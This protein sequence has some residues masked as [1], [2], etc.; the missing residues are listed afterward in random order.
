MEQKWWNHALFRGQ[1]Y[2]LSFISY[3]SFCPTAQENIDLVYKA[4]LAPI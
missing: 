1:V 2:V 3:L 4:A